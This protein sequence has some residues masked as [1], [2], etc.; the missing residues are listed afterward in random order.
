MLFPALL[1]SFSPFGDT[2]AGLFFFFFLP[3][4]T[5]TAVSREGEE[6][7]SYL[8]PKVKN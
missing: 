7:T 1:I 6:Q 4:L 2:A 5:A 8:T 3:L